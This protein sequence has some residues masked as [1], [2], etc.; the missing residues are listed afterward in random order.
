MDTR[1][2]VEALKKLIELAQKQIDIL[3]NGK[4]EEPEVPTNPVEEAP[5]GRGLDGKPLMAPAYSKC[6]GMWEAA[7][8]VKDESG[9]P[10]FNIFDFIPGLQQGQLPGSTVNNSKYA[11][12]LQKLENDIVALA[13]TDWGKEWLSFDENLA[14]IDREYARRFVGYAVYRKNDGSLVRY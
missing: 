3:T 14:L 6:R 10:L 2:L 12:N 11:G 4:P 8:K 1:E 7:M 5:F 9:K 13:K